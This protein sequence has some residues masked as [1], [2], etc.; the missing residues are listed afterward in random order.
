MPHSSPIPA[1]DLEAYDFDLPAQS[2]AAYPSAER[3]DSRLMVLRRGGGVEAEAAVADLA[4]FLPPECLLVA[5]NTKVVPARVRGRR[6]SGGAVEFLLLTPPVLLT[7]EASSQTGRHRAHAQGLVRASRGPRRGE[8]IEFSSEFAVEIAVSLGFG[9]F[10][11][12]LH[13]SGDLVAILERIGSVPLPPYIRREAEE[14][15]KARYQTIYARDDKA[16]SSAAPTA[17]LHFSPRLRR[18]LEGRGIGWAEVTLHVGYGTFSPVRARDI[19]EH[20]MHREHIEISRETAQAVALAK[21][22]GRP[23]V[24]VGTTSVRALE[25]AYRACGEL[26]EYRGETDIFISPGYEFG[27]VDQCI[28]NFHLPKSSLLIMVC[29]LAG[30]QTVLSGYDRAV[31]S[32]YRFFSYG[33]AMLI[34]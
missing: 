5:N 11:V 10:E 7:P 20:A 28:T 27:V 33:D 12:I 26:R 13:W 30:R 14:R 29:A 16:G 4:G 32:G 3:E 19:R 2:I 23:V 24:A 21:T 22:Q 15:D 34:L 25:G 9:R 8:V 17:G 1:F 18:E 31:R 6:P